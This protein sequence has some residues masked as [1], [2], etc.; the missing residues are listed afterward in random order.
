MAYVG[1]EFPAAVSVLLLVVYESEQ[2]LKKE[3]EVRVVADELA[4]EIVGGKVSCCCNALI[5][6]AQQIQLPDF[7]GIDVRTH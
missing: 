6:I 5:I 1:I 3:V 2:T 4:V 7:E